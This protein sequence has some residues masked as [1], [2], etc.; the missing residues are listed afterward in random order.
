MSNNTDYYYKCLSKRNYQNGNYSLETVQPEHIEKIRKWRNEQLEVLRQSKLI[1][2]E[3]QIKYYKN[4]IWSD[5]KNKFPDNIILSFKDVD[6]LI[7]YGGLV[8]IEWENSVAESS[9]LLATELTK[10]K[11]LYEQNFFAFFKLLKLITFDELKLKK[12]VSETYIHRKNHIRLL[13]D[14]GFEKLDIQTK[15]YSISHK[16]EYY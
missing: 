11:R 2:K 5:M 10:D 3:K 14:I 1:S 13:E 8:Y 7:G 6:S 9:F 4:F 12:L 15:K 16:L